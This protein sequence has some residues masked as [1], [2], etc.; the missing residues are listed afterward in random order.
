M[1]KAIKPVF[2]LSFLVSIIA[3]AFLSL[4]K[5]QIQPI[6]FGRGQQGQYSFYTDFELS[7]LMSLSIF[8]DVGTEI[9]HASTKHA[10]DMDLYNKCTGEGGQAVMGFVNPDT[11]HC[12]EILEAE[13]EGVKKWI[14]RVV[15]D[16]DGKWQELTA[17]S[18][19]W[20]S[21]A[22]VEKYLVENSGY[23][24]MWP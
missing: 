2:I 11:N 19:N 7:D 8:A 21:V 13:V 4:P 12:V 20:G 22:E 6:D 9:S 10:D 24:Y 17:F 15:K 23:M 18:D 1:T 3:F 5:S 14:V 16:V